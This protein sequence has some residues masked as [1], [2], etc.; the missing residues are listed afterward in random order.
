MKKTH[1][2]LLVLLCFGAC[3]YEYYEPPLVSA[4]AYPDP[5]DQILIGKCATAGCHNTASKDA[6]A[7]LDL[8][9]W[10][11]MF[12]GT[13]NGAVVIPFRSDF[14]TLCYYTNV[15]SSLGLV[16]QPTMPV[17][18]NPL[19][20][21]E[22][23]LLKN[24][25]DAGAP[26][27]NGFVKF[28]DDPARH[29]FYVVNQGC[30]VVSVFDA[31]RRVAMRMID[32]GQLP[33]ASPPESPHNIKVT[34][35]GKYWLVVFLNADIVQVFSTATD[36]LVKTIPIGNGMAGGWN[37]LVIS[38]DSRKAYSVDYNGGRVAFI[39]I[40]AGTS[41]T[42]GPFPITGNPSP[43][44]H[45]VALNAS[46]DTLYVTCQEISKILKIPVNDVASYEDVNI[47]PPG[48]WQL[49]FPMKPHEIVFSPDYT[50]YFVTCQ[51]TNVNQVRVFTTA[52]NQLVQVIP[53]GRV[54]LEFGVAPASNLLFVTNTEDNF[55]P[56]MRG[57]ISVI[58]MV[59]LTEIKK[60]KVG[61]QPH[62][63]AVDEKKGV[64]YIANRNVSGGTAPH[65]AASC[66]GQNGYLSMID[67]AT[68]ERVLSFKPEV[69]VDPY[70]IGVRAK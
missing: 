5:V 18:Q 4:S 31:D 33:G 19:T 70:A 34:P 27:K 37:T 69:S 64:V 68:L 11:R 20:S 47:N 14:S 60:I 38:K 22:Y 26:D 46:D 24:W 45:G 48:P 63:I 15:D 13:N 3:K 36:Q 44:L 40:D 54:P 59:T 8:S 66:S 35:D 55:F 1:S 9:S 2:L 43:N 52:N 42:V 51:D 23:T 17:N 12:D 29:K 62:G 32:V 65:H 57:S 6:A 56:D 41:N 61:W 49:P 10:E 16:A 67:M 50:K 39:D 30:D 58:D 25:I 28:S 7:G 53:V 21:A